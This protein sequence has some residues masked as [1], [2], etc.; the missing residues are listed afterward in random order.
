M[1]LRLL[2][3]LLLAVSAV[4]AAQVPQDGTIDNLAYTPQSAKRLFSTGS[5]QEQA[6]DTCQ[7]RVF[8]MH[9]RFT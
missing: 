6:A 9:Q 4:A 8:D 2:L 3:I 5:Y 1:L 7:D